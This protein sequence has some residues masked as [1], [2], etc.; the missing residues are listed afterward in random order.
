MGNIR[1][2]AA[3][4]ALAGSMA[5]GLAAAPAQASVAAPAATEVA[6][7]SAAQTSTTWTRHFKYWSPNK[8]GYFEGKVY[9]QGGHYYFTGFLWD[10]KPKPQ[11]YTYVRF[12][13]FDKF[14]DKHLETHKVVSGKK[15]FAPIR[16]KHDFDL[17]VCDAG[18][19]GKHCDGGHDVF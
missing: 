11:D 6:A 2:L 15:Y 12:R 8:E 19:L 13:Y 17:R 4:V 9:K 5:V 16:I 7:S 1:M 14:G 10:G 3:G 18:K